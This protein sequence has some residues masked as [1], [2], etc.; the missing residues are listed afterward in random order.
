MTGLNF[1]PGF[2]PHIMAFEGVIEYMYADINRFKNLSQKKMKFRQYHKKILEVF[3]N[4]FGFYIGCLMWAAYVKNQDEQEILNNY[5]Y[6]K[7][8]NEEENTADT[9]F[10]IRFT[11]LFPKDM[12]YFLGQNFDFDDKVSKILSAYRNF[13]IIN[14]GFVETKNNTDIKL[15]ETINTEEAA[16]FKEKIDKVLETGNLSELADYAGKLIK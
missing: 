12:K 14:R 3:Y 6:G 7:E 9:D 2:G 8:Y 1:D 13:L 15:P 4:N 16:S 5:C 10:L 11:E